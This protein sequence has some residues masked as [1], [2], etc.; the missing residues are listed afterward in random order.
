MRR[1]HVPFA[2]ASSVALSLCVRGAAGKD[3]S[4]QVGGPEVESAP[5]AHRG[6][7]VALRGG[8]ALPLGNV[9]ATTAMSDAVGIQ[10]PLIL[11]IGAKPFEHL[12]IGGYF[13]IA[14]GGAAGAVADV[15]ANLGVSCN[16]LSLRFGGQVQYGFRPAATVNPW[17]GLAI[18]YEIAR[19]SGTNGKNSVDNTLAGLEFAHLMAGVD[20]RLAHELGIGPFADI[21]LGQYST[22]ETKQNAG[23]RVTTLGGAIDDTSL[24]EWITLGV[25]GVFFP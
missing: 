10:V 20:F 17:V 4:P 1:F 23:G 6:F 22:A 19:S 12:F 21:A 3:P 13:G 15:C 16:G 9:T 25:R 11:D 14:E 7:Q 18:G 8:V 5:E 2:F 24:H